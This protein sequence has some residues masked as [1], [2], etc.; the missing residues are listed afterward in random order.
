MADPRKFELDDLLIRPGTYFNPQTEVVVVVD[1]SA[2][3]DGEIFNMED[4]EGAD[5]VLV[6]DEVPLDEHRRDELLESF[7]V[8]YH[9]GGANSIAGDDEEE[10]EDELEEDDQEVGRE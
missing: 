2:E 1:D 5:W 3:I 7:Q 4:F 10:E 9:P 8:T 6:S